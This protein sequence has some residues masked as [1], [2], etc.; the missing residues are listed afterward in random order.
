[1]IVPL[2]DHGPQRYGRL[3]AVAA[4]QASNEWNARSIPG[5]RVDAI[6]LG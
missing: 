6:V 4:R 1:M 5:V 2:A 3:V